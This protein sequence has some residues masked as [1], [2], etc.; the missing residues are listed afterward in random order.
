MEQNS[1]L[2]TPW[3][4]NQKFLIEQAL[5]RT[6][7]NKSQAAKLLGICIRTMRNKCHEFGI[8]ADAFK[9]KM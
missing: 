4:Q 5:S 3:R 9:R 6:N 7:G 2:H 8:K 1:K